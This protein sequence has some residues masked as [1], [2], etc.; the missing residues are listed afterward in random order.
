MPRLAKFAL[1]FA[2]VIDLLGQGLVFP[3]INA[4]IMEPS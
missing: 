2:G 1:L 4:L 3:V